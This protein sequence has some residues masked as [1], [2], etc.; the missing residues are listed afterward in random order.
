MRL[1]I[2]LA[3]GMLV[4][5]FAGVAHA[6]TLSRIDASTLRYDA[7][8]GETNRIFASTDSQGVHVID[9]GATV[10]AGAGCTAPTPNEG[11]CAA[12][13][14]KQTA[15]QLQINTGD[16]DDYVN[17][18][19][20][21]LNLAI[22]DG[23]TGEDE[24]IGGGARSGNWLE[25]GPG[26]DI[27]EGRATADYHRRTSPVTVTVGDDLAN[28]G[29][30]GEG[31]FVS[32]GIIAVFGGEA[33]DDLTILNSPG[34]QERTELEGGDGAD[35]LSILR[36]PFGGYILGGVGPDV[37][38][39]EAK[40]GLVYGSNGDDLIFGGEGPQSL[41]GAGGDDTL[42]GLGGNDYL[43]GN[44][45]ADDLIL[46]SGKDNAAGGHGPDTI[47]ARDGQ[48]DVLSG[49]PGKTDR[50]RVDPGLDHVF[51]VEETF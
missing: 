40:N 50:A 51:D 44:R 36:Y 10:T 19:P 30:A 6:G 39:Q 5:A 22:V 29:E 4:L 24:L 9:T 3:A 47:F 32:S 12:T 35:H 34:V 23:G 13:V 31:D 17:I 49:G 41:E 33:G 7:D 45:G 46:G 28:D 15:T 48:R 21:T 42:R 25:G 1:G 20:G 11:F 27:L 43:F 18:L 8:P 38:H 26:A 2:V 16:Q 14:K 37:I